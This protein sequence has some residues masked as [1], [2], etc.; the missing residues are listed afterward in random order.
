MNTADSSIGMVFQVDTKAN[1][2]GIIAPRVDLRPQVGYRIFNGGDR[3][4]HDRGISREKTAILRWTGQRAVAAFPGWGNV[5]TKQ[6][7]R[8]VLRRDD[9]RPV[10]SGSCGQ[11]Q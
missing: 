4:H 1:A 11:D 8:R 10:L 9:H 7:R 5:F 3:R 2:G 6:H